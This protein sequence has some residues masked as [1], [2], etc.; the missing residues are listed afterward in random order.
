MNDHQLV[1]VGFV[2]RL[3]AAEGAYTRVLVAGDS[4]HIG[5]AVDALRG[6][7][8][9]VVRCQVERLAERLA[10]PFSAFPPEVLVVDASEL[11]QRQLEA[12]RQADWSLPFVALTDGHRAEVAAA[13]EAHVVDVLVDDLRD[14]DSIC[15]GVARVAP[16]VFDVAG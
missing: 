2:R 16:P 7:G 1:D 13:A 3:D 12:I 4:A 8:Y 11:D 10:C 6:F 9:D 14:V 5:T 15:D